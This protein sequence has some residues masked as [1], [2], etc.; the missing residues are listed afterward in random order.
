[1]LGTKYAASVLQ[2]FELTGGLV[3]FEPQLESSSKAVRLCHTLL[4]GLQAL[5]LDSTL[6]DSAI[7]K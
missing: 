2:F 4:V 1:M 6:E 7:D 5:G 3:Y